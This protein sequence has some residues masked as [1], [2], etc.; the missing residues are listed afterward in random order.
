MGRRILDAGADVFVGST[1]TTAMEFHN[2]KPMIMNAG[3]AG[4]TRPIVST[5]GL[6][7]D[8]VRVDWPTNGWMHLVRL[9][10]TACR[11]ALEPDLVDARARV[12]RRLNPRMR[13]EDTPTG[14][15]ATP[16]PVKRDFPPILK[17]SGW[18]GLAKIQLNQVD[19]PSCTLRAFAATVPGKEHTFVTSA[20]ARYG[21]AHATGHSLQSFG[22]LELGNTLKALA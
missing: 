7:S 1:R 4:P 19:C 22:S 10:N 18:D 17:T 13:L 14:F 11:T 16:L 21:T 15:Y 6:R 8:F 5:H 20:D 9:D 12:R 2:G 3:D